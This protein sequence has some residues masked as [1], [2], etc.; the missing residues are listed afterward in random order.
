M[1]VK[2]SCPGQDKGGGPAEGLPP[3]TDCKINACLKQLPWSRHVGA[4]GPAEGLPLTTD[5]RKQ[6][7]FS[8]PSY[9]TVFFS[10]WCPASSSLVEAYVQKVWRSAL[11]SGNIFSTLCVVQA[12]RIRLPLVD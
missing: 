6:V 12:Q 4:V 9:W 7:L 1:H 8:G 3:I 11:L 2:S 10:S 5:F